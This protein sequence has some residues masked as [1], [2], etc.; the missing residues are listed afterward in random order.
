MIRVPQPINHPSSSP[1]RSRA[2][3][4][5]AGRATLTGAIARTGPD[6]R[7]I[8]RDDR[9]TRADRRWRGRDRVVGEVR[10]SRRHRP[11]RHLQLRSLPHGRSRFT[12]RTPGVRQRQRDRGRHG[13]RGVAGRAA[14][15]RC[16][17]A[18]TP[19]IRSTCRR[20]SCR[21]SRL[22]FAGVQNFPTVGLIDGV[23]RQNLEE[24]GMGYHHEVDMIAVARDLDLLTTPYVFDEESAVAM[25]EA[26]ADIIVCHMGSHHG[27]EHRRRHG[28]DA[29]RL[30]R[31]DRPARRGARS[32][33]PDVIVLCHGGPIANPDDS[34][35]VLQRA[36]HP[37]FLWGIEHG[38]TAH[39]AGVEGANRSIQVRHILRNDQSSRETGGRMKRQCT[40]QCTTGCDP[41]R[42]R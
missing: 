37:W 16:W 42:S 25:T 15:S 28:S 33:R 23:F 39:R 34:A 18:S 20:S 2:F 31:T 10:G 36:R 13:P 8:P 38:A 7:T 5:V 4:E 32:V 17:P 40:C 3:H 9:A 41:N 6:P 19:P 11:D 29:R 22:G 24:T 26:G 14:L 27:R 12:R 35:Y 21:S 1:P 30:R